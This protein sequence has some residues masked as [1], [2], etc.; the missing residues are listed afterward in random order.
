M[1]FKIGSTTFDGEVIDD[2]TPQLGGALDVNGNDITSA[3]NNNVVID[4]NGSGHIYLKASTTIQDGAHNFNIASHDGTNGLLLGS[5]LV[6]A[7]GAELNKLDGYTGGASDLNKIA[8]YTGTSAE[9]NVLDL[10]ANEV[11][12]VFKV[13]TSVPSSASDFTGNVKIIMVY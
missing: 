3:S 2:S 10:N 9:L 8:G 1:V 12:G 7:S 5:T 4:P 6:T 11:V 13:A